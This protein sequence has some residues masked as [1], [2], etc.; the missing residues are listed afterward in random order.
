MQ[1]VVIYNKVFGHTARDIGVFERPVLTADS[2]TATRQWLYNRRSELVGATGTQTY[3][4]DYAYSY[5]SIGNRL[6]SSDDFGTATYAANSLNQYTAVNRAIDQSE[7][8]VFRSFSEG[9]SNNFTYDAD[10]NLTQDD[11]FS[12]A[13]DDE[14]RLVSVTPTNPV[15]GSRAIENVYDHRSR[16]IK[17]IVRHYDG[18][19]MGWNVESTHVFVWDGWN[20]V[21]EQTTFADSTTRTIEYF[22]GNDV[23]G[24]E[25]GAGGVGGLLATRIDGV[26]YVP[27]YGGNGNIMMYVAGNGWIAAQY[28]YDPYGNIRQSSGPLASQFAFGFSTKYHDREVNLVA[29]QLRTYNPTYGRWLNRDPIE[30]AGGEN[31]YCFCVNEISFFCDILGCGKFQ[32]TVWGGYWEYDLSPVKPSTP[33]P[34]MISEQGTFIE[35]VL[36]FFT[37]GPGVTY[38]YFYPVHSA[39]VRLLQHPEVKRVLNEFDGVRVDCKSYKGDLVFKAGFGNFISDVLTI[40]NTN[41]LAV[42]NWMSNYS[43]DDLGYQVLGSFSGSYTIKINPETCTKQLDMKL[44]NSWSIDSFTRVPGIRHAHWLPYDVRRREECIFGTIKQEYYYHIE[45]P[46]ENYQY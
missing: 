29:Y 24:S 30:E 41:P 43:D 21:I 42:R 2:F 15:Y 23:S 8:L 44:E 27:V 26:F 39:T 10:G 1:D 33:R 46:Y 45:R 40:F 4:Y 32:S 6:T 37:T 7:Q 9:G 35:S 19:G 31:L 5:D 16:R 13:Y 36:D 3:P 11:R 14:N 38:K 12:Y 25:Q 28:D 17:K 34:T 22:W 18:S 20:I